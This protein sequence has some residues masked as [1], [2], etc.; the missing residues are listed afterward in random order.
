MALP[1]SRPLLSL[2]LALRC[3]AA[4]SLGVPRARVRTRTRCERLSLAGLFGGI[5][6]VHVAQCSAPIFD[7]SE[8]KFL[9][10]WRQK[11]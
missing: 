5:R 10:V 1:S 6:F 7:Y 8:A 4:G 9:G 3:S 11:A 2:S